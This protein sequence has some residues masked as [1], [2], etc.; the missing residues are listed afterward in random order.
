MKCP[1]LANRHDD[2]ETARIIEVVSWRVGDEMPPFDEGGD[3]WMTRRE[4]REFELCVWWDRLTFWQQ[5][6]MKL[7]LWVSKMLGGT[8]RI[9]TM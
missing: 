5:A 1:R 9:L 6:S 2:S 3:V 7:A 4:M 8:D